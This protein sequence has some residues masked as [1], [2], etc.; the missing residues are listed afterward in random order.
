MEAAD[1]LCVKYCKGD[2]T[3]IVPPGWA[4]L[5]VSSW[6][7]HRGARLYRRTKRRNGLLPYFSNGEGIEYISA[8]AN[9][10][11]AVLTVRGVNPSLGMGVACHSGEVSVERVLDPFA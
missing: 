7:V 1:S 8:L 10:M 5:R 2:L 6:W 3:W 11:G 9:N 4:V